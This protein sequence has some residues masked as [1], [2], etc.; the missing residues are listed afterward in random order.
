VR[1]KV[2]Q[3]D[4]FYVP[5]VMVAC[6]PFT[7]DVL[8]AKWLTEPCVVVEVLSPSTE[9]IDRR[10]KA[11]NYRHIPSLEEYILI[12]QRT[13]EVTVFSRSD[14]WRPLVLTAPEHVF[15]SRAVEVNI[16]LANIYEGVR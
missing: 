15:E 2:N 5:D 10:E 14:N 3:D 12:A 1:L 6:G 16:A 7:E 11:L 8:N 4:V 9:S 13:M